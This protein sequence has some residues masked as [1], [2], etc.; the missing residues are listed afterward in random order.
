[1]NVNHSTISS[2]FPLDFHTIQNFE[3]FHFCQKMNGK[4][5]QNYNIQQGVFFFGKSNSSNNATTLTGVGWGY[6]NYVR[7]RGIHQN[8]SST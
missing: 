4:Q 1:M 6:E 8:Y 3:S 5:K 2:F 7:R